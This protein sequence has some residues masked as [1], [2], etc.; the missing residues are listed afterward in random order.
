ME[1]SNR[2]NG[3]GGIRT[4]GA[5]ADTLVFKTSALNY[6][7]TLFEHYLVVGLGYFRN[8]C[9]KTWI[10]N[11]VMLWVKVFICDHFVL[12]TLHT[13]HKT[14]SLVHTIFLDYEVPIQREVVPLHNHFDVIL[15]CQMLISSQF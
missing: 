7:I 15:F 6:F 3:G 12:A 11:F 9:K 4:H 10:I 1:V 8:Q 13:F 2:E 14:Y 5:L